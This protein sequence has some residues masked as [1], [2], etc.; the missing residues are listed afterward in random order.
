MSYI[1]DFLDRH[2]FSFLQSSLETHRQ[3]QKFFDF[4]SHND[5][6]SMVAEMLLF[7]VQGCSPK[8]AEGLSR[9]VRDKL[10]IPY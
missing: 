4:T 5:L 9:L 7:A 3:D 8:Q 2:L 6:F 1:L 10:F